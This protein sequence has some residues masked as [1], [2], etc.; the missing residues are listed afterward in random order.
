MVRHGKFGKA[1]ELAV[2]PTTI[3]AVASLSAITGSARPGDR[4]VGV[5]HARG[6]DSTA[7]QQRPR[8]V[9]LP[10]VLDPRR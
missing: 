7:L 1:R 3:G 10:C 6:R 2:H 5:V 9:S 8:R 4:H